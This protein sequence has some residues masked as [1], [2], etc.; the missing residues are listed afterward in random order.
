MFTKLTAEKAI[1]SDCHGLL[2]KAKEIFEKYKP[3]KKQYLILAK[4]NAE[5]GNLNL[6]KSV[7]H[8]FCGKSG[9]KRQIITRR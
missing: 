9:Q 7:G 1:L 6:E 5:K 4:H 2:G 3:T 8:G